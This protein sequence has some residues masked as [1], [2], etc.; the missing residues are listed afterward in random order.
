[1]L[2]H[3]LS[4]NR[5]LHLVAAVGWLTHRLGRDNDVQLNL[6]IPI[7]IF[8]DCL[9]RLAILSYSRRAFRTVIKHTHVIIRRNATFLFRI[10]L[11]SDPYE[12]S[13]FKLRF[14]AVKFIVE[15]EEELRRV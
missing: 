10:I 9:K 15:L 11:P 1:M 5:I 12:Q 6:V 8:H 14:D 7:S 3:L 13:I 2:L 4:I